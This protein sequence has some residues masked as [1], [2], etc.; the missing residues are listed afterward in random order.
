MDYYERSLEGWP[1]HERKLVQHRFGQTGVLVA[2][3]AHNPPLVLLHGRYTPAPS[4]T[5]LIHDLAVRYRVY[6]IETIGEPG[7]STNDGV[8]IRSTEDYIESLTTTFDALGLSAAHVCGFSFGG[9]LAAQ[10]AVTHPARVASL[11]LLEPAQVFAPFSLRWLLHCVRPYLKPNESNVRQFFR[12]AGQGY[13]GDDDIV[14]L[15]TEAM[16]SSRIKVPEARLIRRSKLRG[17]RMPCQQLLAD[18]SVV[19][20]P[21]RAQRRAER[22]NPAV[23]TFVVKESSH[24]IMQS[25]PDQVLHALESLIASVQQRSTS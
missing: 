21:K 4:W 5:P 25:Q 1:P 12:W 24:F 11:T 17:L 14:K 10:L 7:L 6:A 13:S 8:R 22:V 3:E 15:G 2:G 23:K 19:H 9:W 16:L 18:Q 20:S